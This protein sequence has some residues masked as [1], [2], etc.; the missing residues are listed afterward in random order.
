[1]LLVFIYRLCA[2][3]PLLLFPSDQ[4]SEVKLGN[5]LLVLLQTPFQLFSHLLFDRQVSPDRYKQSEY[6][7]SLNLLWRCQYIVKINVSA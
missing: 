1:M 6:Y 7:L 2:D 4:S 3:I 5:P